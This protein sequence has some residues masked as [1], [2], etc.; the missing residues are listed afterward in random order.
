MMEEIGDE[1]ETLCDKCR[2][3][4]LVTDIK[5]TAKGDG[6][7]LALC[8]KCRNKNIASQIKQTPAQK[9]SDKQTYVCGRCGYRFRFDTFGVAQLRCPYCGR[10]D[11][12][13]LQ[14]SI[15]K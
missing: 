5:Y 10:T 12:L 14:G 11:K 4:T 9:T 6:T 8:S 7:R 3:P 1:R 15:L 2:R 13:Q